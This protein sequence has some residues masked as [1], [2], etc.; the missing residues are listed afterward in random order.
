[1]INQVN[2]ILVM[3]FLLL[4]L[5]G[6]AILIIISPKA[7]GEVVSSTKNIN[8]GFGAKE[9]GLSSI[10]E[11]LARTTDRR[12]IDE[13]LDKIRAEVKSSEDLD[14]SVALQRQTDTVKAWLAEFSP[15]L[16]IE[17][18]KKTK[19]SQQVTYDK[20]TGNFKLTIIKTTNSLR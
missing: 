14:G 16:H 2:I 6:V 8:F 13:L 20:K 5:I 7:I 1:M 12:K 10:M 15:E 3:F 9:K 11:E 19:K 17:D 18:I 4:I